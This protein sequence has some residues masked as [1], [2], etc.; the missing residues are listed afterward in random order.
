MTVAVDPFANQVALSAAVQYPHLD[1]GAVPGE[2][3][4]EWATT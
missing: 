3:E 4:R 2:K 1:S